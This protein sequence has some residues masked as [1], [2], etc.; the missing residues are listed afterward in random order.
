M[1]QFQISRKQPR[2][3]N[4]ENSASE[5]PAND[6]RASL[7]PVIL[8][9]KIFGL[10]HEA[11]DQRNFVEPSTTEITSIHNFVSSTT[12]LRPE[13]SRSNKLS[14]RI[15]RC[16]IN[17]SYGRIQCAVVFLLLFS[18]MVRFCEQSVYANKFELPFRLL[19]I[20]WYAQTT[21]ASACLLWSCWKRSHLSTFYKQWQ[22]LMSDPVLTSLGMKTPRCR[23]AVLTIT[24]IAIFFFFVNNAYLFIALFADIGLKESMQR[25]VC[26]PFPVNAWSL[27]TALS[28]QVLSSAAWTLPLSFAVGLTHIMTVYFKKMTDVIQTHIQDSTTGLPPALRDLRHYH[29]R[30]CQLLSIL[31]RYLRVY[32]GS[33]YLCTVVNVSFLMYHMVFNQ[34]DTVSVFVSLFWL[35][36]LFTGVSVISIS[37][38]RLHDAVVVNV[39]FL[40][41]HMVFNR[42]DTVSVFVGLFWLVS[43]FTGIS[44]IS[45]SASRLHDAKND[46]HNHHCH[47]HHHH[48][49]HHNHNYTNKL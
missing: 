1:R 26:D 12:N 31:D 15:P 17:F 44:V 24:V 27:T 37:A 35:V 19:T 48:H 6:I 20:M 2:Q 18:N 46:S 9:L 28:V 49:H 30:L 29:L 22:E 3:Q 10:Y 21:S 39:S 38:S 23:R 43:L 32:L 25:V 40:M 33:L 47:Y 11:S 16:R 41:Y 34:L 5:E 7:S 42:L 45:I 14:R 13:T 4:M 8:C 36:S